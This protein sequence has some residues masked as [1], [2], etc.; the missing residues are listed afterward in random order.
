MKRQ[1]PSRKAAQG[2]LGNIIDKLAWSAL[3]LSCLVYFADYQWNKTQPIA[4][5]VVVEQ[6]RSL[7]SMQDVQRFLGINVDGRLGPQT[8]YALETLLLDAEKKCGIPFQRVPYPTIDKR[9]YQILS[10]VSSGKLG[11]VPSNIEAIASRHFGAN[12][13]DEKYKAAHSSELILT[14][15]NAALFLGIG[16]FDNSRNKSQHLSEA[17]IAFSNTMN[18][19]HGISMPISGELTETTL[20]ALN[21]ARANR[22]R[23]VTAGYSATRVCLSIRGSKRA[24][25]L[26]TD[27]MLNLPKYQHD[28]LNSELLAIDPY[29]P[30]IRLI[31]DEVTKGCAS[32]ES[33]AKQ[34][35]AFSQQLQ[36]IFDIGDLVKHP[37]RTLAE[38]G[39]DC[40]DADK[41]FLTLCRARGIR[42]ADIFIQYF[43]S[44]AGHAMAG[45]SG[46]FDGKYIEKGG[47]NYFFAETTCRGSSIGDNPRFGPKDCITVFPLPHR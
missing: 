4:D 28:K 12:I 9:T 16:H 22:L 3:G 41:L 18:Y 47:I 27:V 32:A 38:G 20:I 6:S 10:D 5:S 15:E 39:G 7:N 17:L 11:I 33:E 31:A 37:L 8:K 13:M 44:D 14:K 40:D 34:L 43:D 19:E 45:V 1:K 29:D 23:S 24:Y 30:N 42:V 2:V 35:L 46:R 26:P 21:Y 25:L 36:Y